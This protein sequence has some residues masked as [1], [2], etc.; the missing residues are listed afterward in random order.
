MSMSFQSVLSSESKVISE[1]AATVFA[2]GEASVTFDTEATKSLG[3]VET[4]LEEKD[5]PRADVFW[6][7]ELLGTVQLREAG[8]LEPYKGD[9][10][11]RIP[12]AFRDP[13]RWTEMSILNVA[14]MGKFSSDRSI[15][16]YCRHIWRAGPLTP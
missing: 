2:L 4:L 14:R 9:G 16:E 10:Y 3:F 7:N 6:N 12:A 15:R 11:R 5:D 8:V 1:P 13:D